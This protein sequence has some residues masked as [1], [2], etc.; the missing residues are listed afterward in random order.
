MRVPSGFNEAFIATSSG[1][2][3]LPL[4]PGWPNSFGFAVNDSGQVAGEV[5]SADGTASQ[6][7]IGTTAGSAVIPPLPG[8]TQITGYAVNNAGQVAGFGFNGSAYQAFIGTTAGSREI[9]FPSGSADSMITFGSLNNLGT[10]VGQSG[11]RGWIWD[12]SNGT[13]L[14]NTLVPPEWDVNNAISISDNGLILATASYNGGPYQYVELAPIPSESACTFSLTPP[15]ASFSTPTG[16]TTVVT[17]PGCSWSTSSGA[18]WLHVIS[19][20]SGS[21]GGQVTIQMDA[22]PSGFSRVGVLTIAD[23]TFPVT[24]ISIASPPVLPVQMYPSSG[25]GATQT[26]TFTFNDAAGY[27]DLYVADVLVSTFLDGRGA[28]Y[29]ALAPSSATTGYLYLVDDAGD[30]G[31]ASGTPMLLPSSGVLQ[32]SQCSLNGPGSS[33]STAGNQITLTLSI[34]FSPSF[35]GRKA[36]YLAARSKTQNSGWM[37]L[38]TWNVPGTIQA[39]P[40]VTGETG[41]TRAPGGTYTFSFSDTSGYSDLFVLDVLIN[42]FLNG[43]N[44]CYVA[45]VPASATDGYLYLVD[46][47]GDGGYTPESPVLLSSGRVLENSQCAINTAASS[48]SAG[49]S[50]LA[51]TLNLALKT[52]FSGNR[53]FFASARNR[54]SG[55]SGWNAVA[56]QILYP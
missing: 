13:V 44:A 21:G 5:F 9:P 8:W 16:S 30:G 7:F 31:Y 32:N 20:A 2:F 4:P 52:A 46:D 35:A 38:G 50:T 55:N 17:T 45:Y 3:V 28:C 34:T 25:S 27:A 49:G 12:P 56:S 11:G 29:F 19:G 37:G 54:S 53:I 39:G 43:V 36:V 23:Q 41:T 18:G 6:A 26:F 33:I 14:L 42:D 24:Q 51:L 10:V 40:V 1:T 48:A 15:S 47:A 22:N